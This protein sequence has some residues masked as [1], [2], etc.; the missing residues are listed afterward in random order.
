MSEPLKERISPCAGCQNRFIGCHAHCDEFLTW[1]EE[2][3]QINKLKQ[4]NDIDNR[5][6][7]MD[8]RKKVRWRR[9]N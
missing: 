1:Q 9:W 5:P 8:E 3:K 7:R 4:A 2:K 6:Y